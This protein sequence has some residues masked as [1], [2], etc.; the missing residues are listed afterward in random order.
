MLACGF[1]SCRSLVTSCSSF[2]F[3][4]ASTS[5]CAA[6]YERVDV[7]ALHREL[8]QALRRAA[9]DLDRRRILHED[10]HP[11]HARQLGRSSCDELVRAQS[12]AAR[13]ECR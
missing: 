6:G 12:L 11:G 10:G 1:P 7:G 3:C 2:D 8:I 5:F 9:A 13:L 4:A